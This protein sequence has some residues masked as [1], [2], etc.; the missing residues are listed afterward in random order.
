MP[1]R[2]RPAATWQAA[3]DK[4]REQGW[5]ENKKGSSALCQAPPFG[6]SFLSLRARFESAF[7]IESRRCKCGESRADEAFLFAR[8]SARAMW[9]WCHSVSNV[10]LPRPR[11]GLGF[12]T[13]NLSTRSAAQETH[14]P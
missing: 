3:N 5:G 4:A 1:K 7:P 14:R 2:R 8:I 10:K 11:A 12:S 13:G 9:L 6:A